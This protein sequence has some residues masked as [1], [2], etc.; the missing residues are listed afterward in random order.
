MEQYCSVGPAARFGE[1]VGRPVIEGVQVILQ[2]IGRLEI[3]SR[4]QKSLLEGEDWRAGLTL[5]VYLVDI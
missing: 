5:C 4:S 3:P 2:D 1:V